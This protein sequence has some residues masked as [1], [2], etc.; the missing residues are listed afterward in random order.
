MFDLGRFVS[1]CPRG[2]TDDPILKAVPEIAKP[3]NS[4][5][6]AALNARAEP[7]G[8]R[9]KQSTWPPT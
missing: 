7:T 6:S 2:V 3:A 4:D 8:P 1:D 5:P 9:S